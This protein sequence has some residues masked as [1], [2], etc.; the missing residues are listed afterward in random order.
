MVEQT[1]QPT[2]PANAGA[3][4]RQWF[5]GWFLGLLAV[6]FVTALPI[7][8]IVGVA[9]KPAPDVWRHLFET[10]L[11]TYVSNTLILALGVGIGTFAIGTLTAWLVTYYRFPGRKVFEWALLVPLAVPAYVIAYTYTDL[12]DYA[13]TVQ[14]TLRQMF[15]WTSARDYWFPEIRSVGGAITM[16]TLVLYPYVYLLARSAFIHQ[17][18]GVL[19]VSRTLGRGP[20][21]TFW[22]VALPMARPAIVV[23]LSLALLETLNDFG[24]VDFFAVR[25]LT[26]GIFNAWYG[27]YSFEAAAQLSLTLLLFVMVVL[28][29]ERQAR[30][31]RRFE[32]SRAKYKPV[33]GFT[34]PPVQGALAFV[35]CLL[36]VLLGFVVPAWIL[37]RYALIYY[38]ASLNEDFF[39]AALHSLTLS[40]TAAAVAVAIGLFMAYALRLQQ[41]RVL[42]GL[43]WV[44]SL[45]Y[46]MPG[47]ILAVGAVI[48]AGWLD[49][50]IDAY[51][52]QA[53]GISTGLILSGTIV[54][55][56]LGYV[57]RFLVL[58][59]GTIEAGLAKVTRNMDDA[60]RALGHR[61]ATVLRRVHFPMLRGSM[62]TAGLLVFVDCMKELPMTLLLRPFNYETLST[63]VYQFAKDELLEECALG[64]LTIVAAGIGPVV[65]LT[66]AIR[67][68]RPGQG[69]G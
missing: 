21:R 34:L 25:T 14:G 67:H 15:G 26:L 59:F 49:N 43:A 40:A 64:A 37:L 47:A 53:F 55:V 62:L 60:A 35:F 44:A 50:Q 33:V 20:W 16:F 58:S 11:W 23:G 39:S 9:L 2:P 6:A 57:V 66:R 18:S 51:M 17:S 12:L 68:S 28:T 24:T 8:T 63:F 61:P 4:W 52:R 48:P 29:L 36:P 31:G 30:R 41:S 13:G 5:N 19:E 54:A 42:R 27:M 38:K 1:Y 46:G 22:S 7:L 32:E 65:L 56:I 3:S 69:T 45:G 10:V